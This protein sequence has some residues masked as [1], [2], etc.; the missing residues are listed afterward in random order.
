MARE[1]GERFFFSS[2]FL[3]FVSDPFFPV[4]DL[5]AWNRLFAKLNRQKSDSPIFF[6]EALDFSSLN[7]SYS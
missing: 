2:L 3:L 1:K 6:L 7:N 5:H 4:H